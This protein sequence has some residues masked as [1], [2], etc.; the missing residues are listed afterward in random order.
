MLFSIGVVFTLNISDPNFRRGYGSNQLILPP[1]NQPR[2]RQFSPGASL[3][4]NASYLLEIS[5][6][7]GIIEKIYSLAG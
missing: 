6:S 2:S 5:I 3:I 1:D 4:E 7:G